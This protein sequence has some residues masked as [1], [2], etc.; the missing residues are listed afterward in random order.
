M[1]ELILR[2]RAEVEALALVFPLFA[3]QTAG[4]NTKAGPRFALGL[5]FQMARAVIWMPS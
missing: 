5:P 1:D 4:E 3:R 2:I